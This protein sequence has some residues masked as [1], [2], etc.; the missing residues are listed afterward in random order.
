MINMKAHMKKLERRIQW[1]KNKI[2][3]IEDTR[4]FLKGIVTE[5]MQW[6][7]DSYRSQLK[8]LEGIL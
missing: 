1:L 3:C 2:K 7:L 4:K 6:E 5:D 8:T